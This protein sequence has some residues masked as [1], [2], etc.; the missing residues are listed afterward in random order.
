MGKAIISS[1]RRDERS[2]EVH[3]YLTVFNRGGNAGTLCVNTSDADVIVKRLLGADSPEVARLVEACENLEND[4][5]AIPH[6]AWKRIQ[7]ALA[8]FQE[9]P[10]AD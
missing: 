5:G 2:N 4:N 3:T 1:L 9:A 7:A 10:D 8:P 6:H